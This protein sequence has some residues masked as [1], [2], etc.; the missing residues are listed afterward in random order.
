SILFK[1]FPMVLPSWIRKFFAR[2][3]TRP[4]RKVPRRARP[5]LEVLEDRSLPSVTVLGTGGT[6]NIKD[7]DTTRHS[8]VVQQTHT[9]GEFRVQIDTGSPKTFTGIKNIKVDLGADNDSLRFLRSEATTNL[10]GNL[11]V[12]GR[13]GNSDISV[14]FNE[15][16]G[17]VSVTEGN[18]MDSTYLSG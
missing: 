8:I 12:K 16:K 9:Q 5:A 11:S 4:V 13:D 10:A 17:N 2:P 7:S 1:E 15:I 14:E 3:A 18:G 6:P